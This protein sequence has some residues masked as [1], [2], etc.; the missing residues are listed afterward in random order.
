MKKY[1]SMAL[2]LVMCLSLMA[3]PAFA[4]GSIS[5]NKTNYEEG[6][7]ITVTVSGITE[8]M[9]SEGAFVAIY[10]AGS[11]HNAWGEYH[12]PKEGSDELEFTAPEYGLYEMRLYVK[13]GQYD[14]TTFGTSTPFS[15][16]GATASATA[17]L[18]LDRTTAYAAGE[19]IVLRT[20]GITAQMVADRAFVA[21]YKPGTAHNAWGEYHYPREGSDELEFTA[22]Q[23]HGS[24]E[25]RLYRKD[26]EY[27]DE[28]FVTKITFTVGNVG[29]NL[30][31]K[32][33]LESD[34][35]LAMSKIQVTYSEIPEQ[36]IIDGAFIAI[37]RKGAKHNEWGAYAYPDASSGVLE[38]Q[39]PNLNGE[40]EMRLYSEDHFY[41][42][43]TFVMSVPFTLSG[44]QDLGGSDWATDELE[45]AEAFN[46]VPDSLRGQD[47]SK[48]ITR[49]E[50]AAVSVKTYERL[51]GVAAIPA[52]NNPFTDCNDIEVL[53]AYNL[54]ITAGTSDTTF[55]PDSLLTR[56]QAATMLTRVFKRIT[57]PGWTL[58]TDSEFTLDYTKPE[59]FADD[60]DISD[61]AKDS[62][63]FMAANEIIK[64][65]GDNT[66]A[67]K[68]VTPEQQAQ[69]YAQATR[70]QAL[71]IAVRMVENLN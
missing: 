35:Y 48:P 41:S 21:I 11:A 17:T 44:A 3:I 58:A 13:N 39:A 19:K 4:A 55:D 7:T 10:R 64:G 63:Y 61:F 52:I 5:L 57:I 43:A 9:V 27:T 28:T 67:P 38:L 15:V 24:Y 36:F 47:L 45:K 66:F 37:Y 54:G 2:A 31:G 1:L 51:S 8:Q 22:P 18:T 59:P 20:D 56:E 32:I 46:L 53:K 12:Y 26:G 33:S 23:E 40:F 42:D 65:M 30:P 6:E 62:V 69:G 14:D 50:F 70:E 60:A 25:M 71:M 49:A 68:A 29:N 16:G 34:A